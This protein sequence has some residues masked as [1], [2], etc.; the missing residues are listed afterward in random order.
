MMD[1]DYF[2]NDKYKVLKCMSDRQIEVS[3]EMVVHLSQQDVAN[4]LHISKV[5]VNIIISELKKDGYVSTKELR[6]KYYLTEKAA[7]ALSKSSSSDDAVEH[8]V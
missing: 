6:G 2:Y 4:I 7:E 8:K 1:C 3:G 5:K